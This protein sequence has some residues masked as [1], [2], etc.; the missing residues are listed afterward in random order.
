ML[1]NFRVY[2]FFEMTHNDYLKFGFANQNLTEAQFNVLESQ[3]AVIVNFLTHDR[4][5]NCE[6]SE[7]ETKKY[8][9]SLAWQITQL[10]NLSEN[11][12]FTAQITAEKLSQYAVNYA[13]KSPQILEQFKVSYVTIALISQTNLWK[14]VIRYPLKATPINSTDDETN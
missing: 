11:A 5:V 1:L 13:I 3:S 12:L 10:S 9:E 14:I 8:L 7:W 6:V 4:V 2:R